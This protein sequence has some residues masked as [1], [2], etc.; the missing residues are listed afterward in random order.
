MLQTH[1]GLFYIDSSVRFK[2]GNLQL[3]F[4][5]ISA[6][7]VLHFTRTG[8]SI[9]SATNPKMFDYLPTNSL[10]M[11][12]TE[13]TEGGVLLLYRTRRA[14]TSFFHCWLLCALDKKCIAP[15]GSKMIC[16]FA[17]R[18]NKSAGCHRYD[19]SAAS[20]LL[21]NLYNFNVTKYAPPSYNLL[22][23]LRSPGTGNVSKC[24]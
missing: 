5:K 1:A 6:N 19:Q 9:Y 22:Q 14:Y 4:E 15:S 20:I 13:M 16:R 23:V 12:S 2:H 21:A 24:Q 11:K 18:W 17:D 3:Y 10:K 7:G 8:H